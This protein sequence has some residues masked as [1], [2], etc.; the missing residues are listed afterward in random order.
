MRCHVCLQ[1]LGIGA[2]GWFPSRLLSGGV[3][4]VGKV[5]GIGM[6]HLPVRREPTSSLQTCVS[7]T[8]EFEVICDY[9]EVA[10]SNKVEKQPTIAAKNYIT[11]PK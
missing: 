3:E 11:T 6:A 1:S 10:G 7:T 5:F 2:L 9:E 8:V 4:V